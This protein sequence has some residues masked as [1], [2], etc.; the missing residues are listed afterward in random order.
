[1]DMYII[2][3]SQN[4]NAVWKEQSLHN[5]AYKR[6][7]VQN[8]FRMPKET[9]SFWLADD[10]G[11]NLHPHPES[12]VLP[13]HRIDYLE[14]TSV[15]KLLTG[16]GLKPFEERFVKNLMGQLLANTSVN[17]GWT[18]FPDLFSFLRE[19]LTRAGLIAMCGSYLL[20]INPS[21]VQDF[22]DFDRDLPVLAKQYPRW[23]FPGP[24]RSRDICLEAMK[25]WHKF[26]MVHF[27]HPDIGDEPWSQYYG[28]EMVRFR[29]KMWSGMPCINA[30][31]AAS[32]DLGI[33]W[34]C[35]CL[36]LSMGSVSIQSRQD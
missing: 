32:M 11:I 23:L 20:S 3:G 29:H 2:T 33:I 24:Y 17:V 19:E 13:H 25:Q 30:D 34:A 7:S 21:F 1:M 12:N 4:V 27:D 5:K 18:Q 22:W 15:A 35:V 9:L 8:M 10:S 31:S 26:I 14:H 28:V 36:R 6:L 16:P